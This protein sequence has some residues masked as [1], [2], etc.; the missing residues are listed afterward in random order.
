[1]FTHGGILSWMRSVEFGN[2]KDSAPGTGETLRSQLTLI[3]VGAFARL[4]REAKRHLA[5]ERDV[6]SDCEKLTCLRATASEG[7]LRPVF[8]TMVSITRKISI[9]RQISPSAPGHFSKPLSGVR[10]DRSTACKAST[11]QCQGAVAGVAPVL[12]CARQPA[13]LRGRPTR[14]AGPLV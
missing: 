5:A 3:E 4:P 7:S 11:S 12:R 13:E 6:A 8:F 2:A 10:Q 9:M 14:S 1:M